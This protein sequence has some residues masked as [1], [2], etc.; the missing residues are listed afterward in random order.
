[1][2]SY[3]P[4]RG[5]LGVHTLFVF[6]VCQIYTLGGLLTTFRV[7]DT[8]NLMAQSILESDALTTRGFFA[9]LVG[10]EAN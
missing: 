2:S 4:P 8:M 3:P 6:R 9:T 5:P 7:L 1:V 10:V